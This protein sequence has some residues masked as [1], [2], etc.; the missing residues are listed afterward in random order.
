MHCTPAAWG[1]S[2]IIV[3]PCCQKK[4]VSAFIVTDV[5]NVDGRV[6]PVD[7]SVV[8]VWMPPVTMCDHR[9]VKRLSTTSTGDDLGVDC[10]EADPSVSARDST[11]WLKFRASNSRS[12]KFTLL[13][14]S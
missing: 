3:R 9:G 2:V 11:D 13:W 12:S 14:V 6:A 5:A 7:D 1:L 8:L 4:T 10:S